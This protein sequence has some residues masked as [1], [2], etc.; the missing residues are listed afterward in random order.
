MENRACH[1]LLWLRFAGTQCQPQ[2]D[3]GHDNPAN[4][5]PHGSVRWRSGEEPGDVR[6]ERLGLIKAKDCEY[7]TTDEQSDSDDPIHNS[8]I[9]SRE[10][11]RFLI[12]NTTRSVAMACAPAGLP[13]PI[14]S[15]STLSHKFTRKEMRFIHQ[16]VFKVSL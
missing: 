4:E 5:H 6:T 15:C 10:F 9:R 1:E 8:P 3:N 14:A 11:G 7:D 13:V 2:A 16:L 12:L